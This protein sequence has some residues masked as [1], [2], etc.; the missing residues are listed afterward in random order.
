MN[1][2]IAKCYIELKLQSRVTTGNTLP[3]ELSINEISLSVSYVYKLREQI[4][5]VDTFLLLPFHSIISCDFSY[6][7]S[8]TGIFDK[9]L[10][11]NKNCSLS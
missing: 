2:M 3:V 6:P 1:L 9:L 10:L 11:C 7:W 8:I 4:S 5:L